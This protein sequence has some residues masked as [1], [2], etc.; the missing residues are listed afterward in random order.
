VRAQ[1]WILGDSGQDDLMVRITQ[2]ETPE[3]DITAMVDLVFMMN[4]YF[5]VT[6]VTVALSEVNLPAASHVSALNKDTAVIITVTRSPDG[7]GSLVYL[8]DGTK[9]DAVRDTREQAERVQALVEQGV[10][11]GLKDVLIK[12][13]KN[14]KLG[15][16]FRLASAAASVEGVKLHVGAIEKEASD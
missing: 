10:G 5:L 12:A 13:E 11:T 6:F 15:D 2:Q 3:F 7:K 4:I 14:V 8:G 9:G 16:V 1:S